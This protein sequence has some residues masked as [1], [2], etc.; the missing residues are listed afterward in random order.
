M[1]T[2]IYS[3]KIQTPVKSEGKTYYGWCQNCKKTL[4]VDIAKRFA[5]DP[6][7]KN[8]IDKSAAFIGAK[9]DG[10]FFYFESKENLEKF[11]YK[12]SAS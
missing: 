1:V 3:S 2:D 12:K 11:R 6:I 7:R 8:K 10:G 5:I 4:K 9:K